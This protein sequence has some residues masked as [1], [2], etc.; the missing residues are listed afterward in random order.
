MFVYAKTVQKVVAGCIG[1]PEEMNEWAEKM[2]DVNNYICK[3]TY[4]FTT[5]CN[6][7]VMISVL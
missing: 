2:T 5:V 7:D 6:D 4:Q 1:L 3:K